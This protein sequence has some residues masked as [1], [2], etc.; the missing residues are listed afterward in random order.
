MLREVV[1]V[2]R[3]TVQA[4]VHRCRRGRLPW[5]FTSLWHAKLVQHLHGTREWAFGDITAW[6]DE[7]DAS[8]LFWLMGGG[9]TGKSVL[10]AELLYRLFHLVVA[11]HFCRHDD[12]EQSKPCALLRSLAA[13]LCTRLPGFEAALGD[14]PAAMRE[15]TDPKEVFDALF[16]APL[17][18]LAP[19]ADGKPRLIIIDA[20]DEIPKADQPR[21]LNVIANELSKLPSWLRIFTT[22][23]EEPQ[24]KRA[25]SAFEPR[26]LRAD[27]R[28]NRADVEVSLRRTAGKFVK[29]DVDMADIEKVAN[30][31]LHIDLTGK[32]IALQ[33]PLEK[34]KAI[35]GEVRATLR[36]RNGYDE[37][38]AI[39]EKRPKPTQDTDD[40]DDVYAKAKEAQQILMNDIASE[41]VVDPKLSFLQHPAP[42]AAKHAWV[43]FADSPGVKGEKRAREKM[44]NDYDGHANQLKDLARLTLRFND[45]RNLV[46]GYHAL[47]DLGYDIVV[48]KNKYKF[49]TPMG[50]SDLNLVVAVTLGDGTPYLCEMQL[51]L[52]AMLDAKNEAHEHYEIIRSRLPELCRGTPVDADKLESF[53]SGR[54]NNS[55]LDGAVA[56]LSLRADGL[57]LYAHLLAEHLERAGGEI[58][59]GSLDA[60]PAGLGEV[61]ATNF[62]R[63]FPR[64]ADDDGWAA[65][66]PLVEL[67]AAAPEPMK[68][69][70][71]KAM[72]GIT[73]DA[74]VFELTSLFFPVRDDLIHVLHKTVRREGEERELRWGILTLVSFLAAL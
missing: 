11:W 19:P 71:A 13:M 66:L 49:P 67:V 12:A 52:I 27:E 57:F 35:Y 9:G 56:A 22:S 2:R 47:S 5:G 64:G 17:R 50:Y 39:V 68:V 3:A 53:I 31:E 15:S 4:G 18:K 24:I 46:T 63:A 45:P 72:L 74:R 54:L 21:L 61:Y 32:L 60:L 69:E 38:L 6:L 55:A 16:A 42:G 34:S 14:V 8:Q 41:W 28:K 1:H 40:F 37:M 43:E 7:R 62:L 30:R 48:V 58:D 73:G 51:N 70:T 59:F 44:A 20:L 26:E 36:V 33:A 10:T 25:L 23:R 65:A 29:S